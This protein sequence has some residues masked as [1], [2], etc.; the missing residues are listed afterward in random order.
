MHHPIDPNILDKKGLIDFYLFL[1]KIVLITP[2]NINRTYHSKIYLI[3]YYFYI[4]MF[5]FH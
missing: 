3:Y 2:K 4:F 1:K 5:F